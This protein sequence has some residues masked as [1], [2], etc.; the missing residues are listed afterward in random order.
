MS[1]EWCQDYYWQNTNKGFELVHQGDQGTYFLKNVFFPINIE[2][3]FKKN[4]NN[5][6]DIFSNSMNMRKKIPLTVLLIQAPPEF[7]V[8]IISERTL[9][10]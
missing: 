1:S 4:N 2:L 5:P 3:N 8:L 6:F 10:K 7:P 9:K